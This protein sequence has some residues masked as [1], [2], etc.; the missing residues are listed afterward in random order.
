MQS[1]LDNAARLTTNR[2]R[3]KAKCHWHR[4][5]ADL[6][7]KIASYLDPSFVAAHLK[8]IDSSTAASLR[9]VYDKVRLLA[10]HTGSYE[11]QPVWP[12]EAFVAH[13]G[14]P[15]PWRALNL[16]TRVRILCAAAASG[17]AGSLDAALAHAGCEV[18]PRVLHAAAAAGNAEGC[19][20]LLAMGGGCQLDEEAVAAAAR[21]GHLQLVQQLMAKVPGASSDSYR[22][23]SVRSNYVEAAGRGACVGGRLEVLAWLRAA[24][25]FRPH[26]EDAEAAAEAGQAAVVELL[27]QQLPEC[28]C[29]YWD[30]SDERWQLLTAMMFGCPVE[31]VARHYDRL[32]RW[33]YREE[34]RDGQWVL[35]GW[36]HDEF[37]T[38]RDPDGNDLGDYGDRDRA[39]RRLLNA[40]AGSPTPCWAAK[41]DLLL[42][43]WGPQVMG[44]LLRGERGV[45]KD[46]DSRHDGFMS[47]KFWSPHPMPGYLQR[48]RACGWVP[49]MMAVEDAAR[50][51]HADALTWLWDDCGVSTPDSDALKAALGW[52]TA[53]GHMDVLRLL[54]ERGLV[55]FTV[56]HVLAEAQGGTWRTQDRG[57]PLFKFWDE[58]SWTEESLA[59]LVGVAE[60]DEVSELPDQH[61]WCCGPRD[62][63]SRA[64]Y[65]AARAGAGI[66][67]LAALVA[68]G[69]EVQVAPVAAGGSV[70]A[71]AWA[72]EELLQ[73]QEEGAAKLKVRPSA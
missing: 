71:L 10:P 25:G 62:P 66:D 49:D 22:R 24:H 67:L 37:W 63:W 43:R 1:V 17:H 35:D 15:E 65:R 8:L 9:G 44:A 38:F 26:K 55:R 20:L 73:D 46:W 42:Q 48:L 18:M 68:R 19:E 3:H 32:W 13:W 54:R 50:D 52:A 11:Q 36:P 59:W 53:P 60:D 45:I 30:R 28:T 34:D 29:R 6:I 40:A 64:F 57:G 31:V 27:L 7:Q 72:V 12:G 21:G 39:M 33:W 58:R 41:L 70:E 4:L 5:G 16:K 56:R 51:G 14:R 69:A 47:Y 2:L 23:Y 61:A